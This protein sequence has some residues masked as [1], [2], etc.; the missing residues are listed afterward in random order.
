MLKLSRLKLTR[1]K[2]IIFFFS[3]FSFLFQN[4]VAIVTKNNGDVKYKKESSK[5][6]TNRI[7]SG[8]ELFNN[9][10]LVTGNDGFIMFAYL[11][12]G[13][14]IKVH[15]DSEV[16]VDGN[17]NN[18]TINK[19]VIINDGFIKF[20]IKKQKQNE[21]KVVTPTSVASVKGTL[22]YVDT[23]PLGDV[24][25]GFEGLVEVLNIE[26]QQ[27]SSLSKSKKITSSPD[28]SI[29]VEEIVDEDIEYIVQ[30]QQESGIEIEEIEELEEINNPEEGIEEESNDGDGNGS[31]EPDDSGTGDA[32]AGNEI[33]EVVITFTNENGEQKTLTIKFIEQ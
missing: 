10:L 26:S 16:L 29:E 3:L 14:L 8:L 15:K 11:D 32:T 19:Q 6:F 22:F 31:G 5:R 20:D 27:V 17:L 24:F 30:V 7:N 25:Y 13:S 18:N 4:E 28:G 1:K 21:F 12:D 23:S 9:D 33:Q 2:Y